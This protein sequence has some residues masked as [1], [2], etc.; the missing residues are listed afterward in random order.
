MTQPSFTP[1]A[2]AFTAFSH[3]LLTDPARLSGNKLKNA[4]GNYLGCR[5]RRDAIGWVCGDFASCGRDYWSLSTRAS[6][7]QMARVYAPP[8]P[9]ATPYPL[10]PTHGDDT[11]RHCLVLRTRCSRSRGHGCLLELAWAFTTAVIITFGSVDW[12]NTFSNITRLAQRRAHRENFIISY[13]VSAHA[14]AVRPRV[15]AKKYNYAHP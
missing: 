2:D 13:P 15:A 10:G 9:Y 3:R 1:L 4:T 11:Q 7:M 8:N 6:Q 12:M 14:R 5:S